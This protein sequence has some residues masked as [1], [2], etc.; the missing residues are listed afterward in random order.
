MLSVSYD[1][2]SYAECQ[3]CGV[4]VMLSISMINVTVLNVTYKTFMLSVSMLNVV[5]LSVMAPCNSRKMKRFKMKLMAKPFSIFN[6]AKLKWNGC[7]SNLL[8]AKSNV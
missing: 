6:N 7:P 2:V 1:S 4:L 5:I 8:K 3:L